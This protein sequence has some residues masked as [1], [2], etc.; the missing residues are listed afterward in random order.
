MP[1]FFSIYWV[2]RNLLVNVDELLSES[3]EGEA[4][5]L[6]LQWPAPPRNIFIVKKDCAPTVTEALIEFAKYGVTFSLENLDPNQ[7]TVAM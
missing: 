7:F 2:S 1:M 3:S 6:S 4:D 5:L